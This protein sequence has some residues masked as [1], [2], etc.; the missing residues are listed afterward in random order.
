MIA[1][2]TTLKDLINKINIQVTLFDTEDFIDEVK[3][4]HNER[5]NQFLR[6]CD[7]L[8]L[9]RDSILRDIKKQGKTPI[10]KSTLEENSKQIRELNKEIRL[11]AREQ[12]D[13]IYENQKMIV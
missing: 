11:F 9:Q 7:E 10:L 3:K 5:I 2:R 6:R 8:E 13:Y 4:I 1:D 12:K